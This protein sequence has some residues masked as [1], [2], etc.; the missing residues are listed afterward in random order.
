MG[1]SCISLGFGLVSAFLG[2]FFTLVLE[3][4]VG[5]GSK[6]RHR[7]GAMSPA[8]ICVLIMKHEY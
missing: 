6:G 1:Q 8:Q 7:R 2:L 5:H 4:Q 3:A